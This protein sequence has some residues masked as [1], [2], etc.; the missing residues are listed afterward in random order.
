MGCCKQL[1]FRIL[2]GFIIISANIPAVTGLVP[3]QLGCASGLFWRL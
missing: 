3:I 2:K 1:D